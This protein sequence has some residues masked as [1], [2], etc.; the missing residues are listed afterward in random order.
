M[1]DEP[2]RH[3][4]DQDDANL[5]DLILD[6]AFWDERYQSSDALWS[7]HPNPQLVTEATGLVPGAALDVGCG[8]GADA[9]WLAEHGWQV[10]AVDI[11]PVA[12]DRGA[13]H[14]CD[15]GNDVAQRITW[16][17]AD[18]TTWVP[19]DT[20]YELVSAQFMQLPANLRPA[21]HCRLAASVSP[22]GSLLVVGHHPSDLQTTVPR[23]PVRE[24]FFTAGDVAASLDPHR[25]D[26]VVSE[27]RARHVLDPEGRTT[28][29][30][31]AVL[32]ARRIQDG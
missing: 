10:T 30:H 9:I 13:A 28:T 20:T 4:H 14:A 1:T 15:A 24:L 2:A 3:D 6:Q 26:V 16:L 8:E 17:H 12:L 19:A 31:D 21:L 23:P 25:W 11:S 5:P 7:G 32:R 27:S 29:I 22:G 18:L